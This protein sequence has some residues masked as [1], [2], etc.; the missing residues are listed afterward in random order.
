MRPF[1]YVRCPRIEDA[2][3]T[4]AEFAG[5]ARVLA[6]GTDLLLELRRADAV[7]PR[8]IVDISRIADLGGIAARDG[9]V[10]VGPL[11][12][13]AEISRS[14]VVRRAAPF[15]AA[16]AQSVGSAQVR[17]RGT[18]GGN[19]MNAATCAD[20][21]PP[22]VALGARLTLQS[23][24]GRREVPIAEFFERPYRTRARADEILVAITFPA[25]PA[26]ARSAYVK[27]G[28]RNAVAIA[29]L[30]VA[31]VLAVDERGLV[32][33]ARIVPGAALP[34]WKRIAEAEAMLVGEPPS[35]TVFRAA[36]RR[37]A[38]AM[39]TAAGRRWSTEYKEPVLAVLV[40][41]ALEACASPEPAA[42]FR[43]MQ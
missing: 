32:T 12:T 1:D 27:L 9:A 15:L 3:A 2:C 18:V 40:R 33:E 21:V 29:R 43:G 4:L 7:A 30:S 28:R 16:A 5:E 24:R 10:A 20:T 41:R 25:L 17:N 37:T 8:A 23:S 35:D 31:A 36:G 34:V 22:L 26:G 11:A 13:H 42:S 6:G 14:E 19:V 38:E 39:V